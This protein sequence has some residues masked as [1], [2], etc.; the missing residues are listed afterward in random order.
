MDE[1]RI[2]SDSFKK[3][4]Q[5][6]EDLDGES[7]GREVAKIDRS[8]SERKDSMAREFIAT[9]SHGAAQ[10]LIEQ[11]ERTRGRVK[12]SYTDIAAVAARF[13]DY[14]KEQ[15]K[16]RCISFGFIAGL[17]PGSDDTISR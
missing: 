9:L 14:V 11:A 12:G 8:A 15:Y 16:Q 10:A 2:F 17:G 1:G 6:V 5:D 7:I 3:L 13:P 4:C